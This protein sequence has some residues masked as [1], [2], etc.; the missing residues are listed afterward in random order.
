MIDNGYESE[1]KMV[2]GNYMGRILDETGMDVR[3]FEDDIGK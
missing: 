2:L 3:M 1:D